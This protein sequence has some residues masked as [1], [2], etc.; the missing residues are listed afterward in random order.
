MPEQA[1]DEIPLDLILLWSRIFTYVV[2]CCMHDI[3][4][5]SSLQTWTS[6]RC[7]GAARHRAEGR[8]RW[9]PTSLKFVTA[10]STSAP[11]RIWHWACPPSSPWVDHTHNIYMYIV[12]HVRHAK[13]KVATCEA[14]T[15]LNQGHTVSLASVNSA[16]CVSLAS[17]QFYL[18]MYIHSFTF[19]V[20]A[21]I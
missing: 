20:T 8:H 7:T 12:I 18:Y 16:T 6:W 5:T 13:W 2:R 1:L 10:Y 17:S 15:W 21:E 11:S 3:I 14:T 9:P 4:I 19:T